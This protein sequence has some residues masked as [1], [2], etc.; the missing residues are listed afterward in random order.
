MN[1]Q[2]INSIDF[3]PFDL[4]VRTD[5]YSR[6]AR[7]RSEAPVYHAHRARAW[8]VSRYDDVLAVLKD[9]ERFS[10]DAVGTVQL[11]ATAAD[12]STAGGGKPKRKPGNIATYDGVDH[13]RLRGI[14]SR[15]FTPRRVEGWR[16]SI[17]HEVDVAVNAM[18]GMSRFDVIADLAAV[19]P[20]N[21][22][23]EI[24]GIEKEHRADFKRWTDITVAAMSGSIRKL[25]DEASGASMVR[26][27]MKE[28][29]AGVLRARVEQPRDDMMSVLMRAQDGDVLTPAEVLGFAAVLTFAGAETVTHLIGN[30]VRVLIGAQE[31]RERVLGDRTLVGPLLEETLRWDGPVQYLFRR[32]TED[33]VIAGTTIPEDSIVNLLIGSANRDPLR[34]GDDAERFD[35]DR[36]TSGHLGFGIG[37]HFCLGAALARMEARIVFDRL[38][39][40]LE[41]SRFTG[42]AIEPIDSVQFRGVRALGFEALER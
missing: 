29:L 13:A 20:I 17:E 28:H 8:V 16:P 1:S 23:A 40:L 26:R 14:V 15:A 18:R 9:T 2:S 12:S 25:G 41:H 6:Y 21:V 10:S 31:V 3:D 5:P 7:L 36:D 42:H 30:A 32:T 11:G 34:W 35:L 4:G 22:I 37:A 27:H 24:I 19:V 39:P 38:L 33:V